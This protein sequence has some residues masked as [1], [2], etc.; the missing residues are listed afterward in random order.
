MSAVSGGCS[1]RSTC[2]AAELQTQQDGYNMCTVSDACCTYLL[3]P[4]AAVPAAPA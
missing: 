4:A 1:A 2:T 3:L